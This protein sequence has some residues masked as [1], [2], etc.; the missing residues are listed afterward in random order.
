MDKIYDFK[1]D[2]IDWL[3]GNICQEKL[4]D[5]LYRLDFPFLDRNNDFTEIYIKVNSD[6]D[7][8]LSDDGETVND[9]E[10]SGVDIFSSQRRKA[11]FTEILNSHG[12][13][14]DEY[15][16][17]TVNSSRADLPQKKHMLMQCMLQ[18]SDMFYLSKQQTKSLFA[19]DVRNFFETNKIYG[20]QG[21]N[22]VGKSGLSTT[23]DFTIPHTDKAPERMIKI[24]PRLDV[25]R[26]GYITFLWE[27]TE[28]QRPNKSRLFVFIQDTD[29]SISE[30][31]IN[32]M[33]Q[34]DIRPV[35]WS[36][37]NEII[38]ELAA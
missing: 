14:L 16:A 26:A 30:S 34:Y 21:A 25:Q 19:E 15:E 28:A 32:A 17:L 29:T 38:R 13:K 7:F 27:D 4:S 37:R 36:R 10:M 9:L 23:Y 35:L 8:T 11:I 6:D 2:Y 24:A 22:F 18:V 20:I 1:K 31:A 33:V 12:V 5:T 3:N